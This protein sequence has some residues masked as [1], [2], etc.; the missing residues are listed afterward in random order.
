MR[1]SSLFVFCLAFQVSSCMFAP[2][3]TAQSDGKRLLRFDF[4]PIGVLEYLKRCSY[5]HRQFSRTHVFNLIVDS[6]WLAALGGI[7]TFASVIAFVLVA[8]QNEIEFSI[9]DGTVDTFANVLLDVWCFPVDADHQNLSANHLS[10]LLDLQT[11]SFTNVVNEG[12]CMIDVLVF[13]NKQIKWWGE[14]YLL[15]ADRHALGGIG[16]CLTLKTSKN[17]AEPVWPENLQSAE[18]LNKLMKDLKR[19][20]NENKRALFGEGLYKASIRMAAQKGTIR[21][22]R[23]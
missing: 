1:F 16:R 14:E 12:K 7:A 2:A 17:T 15:W 23:V 8:R 10:Q 21:V 20:G 19:R 4:D 11:S 9:V 5:G 18:S 3:D 13:T 6:H 22:N